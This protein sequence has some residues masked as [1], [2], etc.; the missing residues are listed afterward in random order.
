MVLQ[1]EMWKEKL[2]KKLKIN[3][4]NV[5]IPTTPNP[6][7]GFLLMVPKSEIKKL[8]VSVDEAIKTIVSA[9]IIK[10]EAKQKKNS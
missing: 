8:N 9:G 4:I 10:L 1:Q 2:K 7:S 3:M 6:T 5:F